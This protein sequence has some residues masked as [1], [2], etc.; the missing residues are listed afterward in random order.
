MKKVNYKKLRGLQNLPRYDIGT[1]PIDRG[2][3]QNNAITPM[4]Y[5]QQQQSQ[6]TN[7]FVPAAWTE[8]IGK[9][10][11]AGKMI[12]DGFKSAKN[13]TASYVP[14]ISGTLVSTLPNAATSIA[15]ESIPLITST[16]GKEGLS[17]ASA[18]LPEAGKI[19][20]D[21]AT[22]NSLNL[23]GKEASE[24]IAKSAGNMAGSKALS[25]IGTGMNV[26]G[27]VQG[28]SGL[29]GNATDGSTLG[30]GDLYNSSAKSTQYR[31]GVAYESIDGYDAAGADKYVKDQNKANTIGGV[32]NGLQ[33]GASIGSFFSPVGTAIGAGLGAIIGGITSLFGNDK[34][35]K[36]YEEAKR[37]YRETARGVNQQNES[38]AA[39]QGI[40][41]Q[42][43]ATHADKGLSP[44][45]K[46]PNA[47][48]QGGEPI[49]KV[50]RKGQ[51]TGADMFPITPKTPERVDNIPV[52]LDQGNTKHGVI[53]NKIDPFT[54]ERLAVEGRPL[55][56]A[57]KDPSIKN[58]K[59]Y[60]DGLKYLLDLQDMI[61]NEQVEMKRLTKLPKYNCGKRLPKYDSGT[62][63]SIIPG[64]LNYFSDFADMKNIQNEPIDVRTD[65]T[66]NYNTQ[67]AL[68]FMPTSIDISPELDQINNAV[69]QGMYAINQ[70]NFAPGMR[71]AMLSQLFNDRMRNSA[72]AYSAKT[73]KEN[74]LRAAYA[75]MLYNA[76]EAEAQRRQSSNARYNQNLR[77][78]VAAKRKLIDTRRADMQS[79]INKTA[80]NLFNNYMF[81]KNVDLWEQTLSND[82]LA[83]LGQTK[84]NSKP[85]RSK[86][87][88]KVSKS[89]YSQFIPQVNNAYKIWGMDQLPTLNY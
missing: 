61:P 7:N 75:N 43:Y 20:M 85:T 71:S 64:A 14:Q 2:Y 60:K 52:R 29:Y 3:Q 12:Y 39:S 28:L 80:E 54:G 78:A 42:Y 27:A 16:I 40:A 4:A 59:P 82:Q 25:A 65:Y 89:A 10:A 38:V 88:K 83:T 58:K 34:R 30:F 46:N 44:N 51:I 66:P 31:N 55:V 6:I 67:Q 21:E 47:L 63:Y 17:F 81:N 11:S 79:V 37:V 1:S 41:N 53:G 62:A 87:S 50:N 73:N 69:R 68:G 8:S 86:K 72:N 23:A 33:T 74:E 48:V 76:G 9:A 19:V 84:T 13:A 70:S 26:I 57:L 18:A 5:S 36:R 15:S 22:V 49:V 56:E 24:N 77:E 45:T 35:K 32:S